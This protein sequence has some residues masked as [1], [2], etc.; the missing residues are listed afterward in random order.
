MNR[1]QISLPRVGIRPCIDGRR[2]GVREGLET[3][4]MSMAQA[5]AK[6]IKENLRYS[7]GEPVEVIIADS[8]IGGVA[9]AARCQQKF[10]REGVSVTLTV[11]PCW[12]Y[13]TEI[14]RAHV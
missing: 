5:A 9:E 2:N 11:S 10:E 12:C 4:T 7:N 13:S 3:Q 6:L 1:Y 14:G 8:T